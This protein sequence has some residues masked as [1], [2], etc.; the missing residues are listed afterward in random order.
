MMRVNKLTKEMFDGVIAFSFS[1]VGAMGPRGTMGFYTKSGK[2][3]QVDYL[4]KETAYK[5]V[6]E[7][8]PTL[9]GCYWNGP[10]KN[11]F[12]SLSTIVI[13]A[14][15][16]ESTRISEGYK[17]LY[18]DMGNHLCVQ[19]ELFRYVKNLFGDMRNSEITFAWEKI[20]ENAKI[21]EKV[22]DITASYRK[23][24]EQ[25][26]KFASVL[27]ELNKNPEYR[28]RIREN[29]DGIDG[30]LAVLKEFSGIEISLLEL[31]QFGLR[32]QELE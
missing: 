1:E 24:K 16:S 11:E 19:K 21:E 27:R 25:D 13:G 7:C 29:A 18:L 22:D 31:K 14:D 5:K 20:L 10:M 12:A 3:F 23:Q 6:K 17:H 26:E 2:H 28:R 32:Q 8:F 4:S 15:S 30:M 9:K